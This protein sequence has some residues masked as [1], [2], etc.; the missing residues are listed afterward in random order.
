MLKVTRAAGLGLLLL[1]VALAPAAVAQEQQAAKAPSGT[2]EIDQTQMAFIVS[3]SLGGGVLHYQGEAHDFRVG[4]LGVGGIGIAEIRA[5]G[6]VYDLNDLADFPGVYGE[7]HAGYA[8]GPTRSGGLW[9]QNPKGVSLRLDAE[10][11]G[12]MLSVGAGGVLIRMT[13]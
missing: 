12:L 11:D 5:R 3:G 10:R 2:I 9:L 7:A 4:G 8:M 6:E 13:E 1:A